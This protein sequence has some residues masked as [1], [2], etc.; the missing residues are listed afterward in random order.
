LRCI[1]HSRPQPNAG[2][3]MQLALF[4]GLEINATLHRNKIGR[5]GMSTRWRSLVDLDGAG[6]PARQASKAVRIA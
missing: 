5:C 4:E 2:E 6:V 1:G 3:G